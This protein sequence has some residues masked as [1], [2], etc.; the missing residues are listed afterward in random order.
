M[1]VQYRDQEE[2]NG[3]FTNDDT[4]LAQRWEVT[5]AVIEYARVNATEITPVWQ[6]DHGRPLAQSS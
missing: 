6:E 5:R 4:P 2:W 3:W 1:N